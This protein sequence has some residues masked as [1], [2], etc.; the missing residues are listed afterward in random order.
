[1]KEHGPRKGKMLCK[2]GVQDVSEDGAGAKGGESW[3]KMNWKSF[4][5]VLTKRFS[6]SVC[7]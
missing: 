1:M 2:T 3:Q 5:Y 6:V 4:Q 7:K